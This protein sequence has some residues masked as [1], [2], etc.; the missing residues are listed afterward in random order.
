MEN[1]IEILKPGTFVAKNGKQVTITSEDLD[2][3][4]QGFDPE[5]AA[6]PLVF[7]HPED[8]HPAYGWADQLKR[9]GD[10]LLARFKQV[11]QAVKDLVSAGHY[12]K[13]SVSLTPD[14]KTLRHVGLLGA[15]RPAVPGLA[16]VAFKAED[17][18]ILIYF[19]NPSDKE[20]NMGEIEELRAK[21][22]AEEKARK[23]AEAKATAAETKLSES[24]KQALEASLDARIDTLVGKQILA[25]D[26]PLVKQIAMALGESGQEIEL[27]EGAGKKGLDAHLFDFLSTLP[28][29]K[30]LHEF[31]NPDPDKED[32]KNQGGGS[33]DMM[34]R[35]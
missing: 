18:D 19:S 10:V 31:S 21:L 5:K 2:H 29:R 17:D 24:K 26:K 34:G 8:N 6:A 16:D 3:L 33:T 14:K 25:G 7:G 9:A 27:S 1:W 12:K 28:D 30:L 32:G 35:V 23:D 11:P 13:I 15:A 22:A 20:T 4:V